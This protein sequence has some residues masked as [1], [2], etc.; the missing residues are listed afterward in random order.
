VTKEET[1]AAP[2]KP[3]AEQL[4]VDLAALSWQRS[5]DGDGS[6][7]VAIVDALGRRWVLARVTGTGGD[8]MVYSSHEWRC[9]IDGVRA[10][11]FDEAAG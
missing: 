7:E 9:F 10:G 6:L 2:G 8:V 11:E 1:V 3:T 5:G 4:G